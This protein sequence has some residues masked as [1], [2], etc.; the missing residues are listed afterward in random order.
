LAHGEGNLVMWL[1]WRSA[2]KLLKEPSVL[3]DTV[4]GSW[5]QDLLWWT[6]ETN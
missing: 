1:Q 2:A 6:T 5:K 3:W 4:L